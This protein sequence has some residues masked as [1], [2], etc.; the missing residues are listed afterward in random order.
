MVQ[1]DPVLIVACGYQLVLN[2]T[3]NESAQCCAPWSFSC[4]S[5]WLFRFLSPVFDSHRSSTTH[6]QVQQQ[7]YNLLLHYY[8]SAHVFFV[9]RVPNI[10]GFLYNAVFSWIK[11]H[12]SSCM[13]SI[14]YFIH[15]LYSVPVPGVEIIVFESYES[16]NETTRS[17][18]LESKSRLQTYFFF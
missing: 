3:E 9:Y 6:K 5:R 12:S 14:L 1:L 7:Q 8:S 13:P 16:D 2:S 10:S 11:Q 4:V 15:L 17:K 18:Q